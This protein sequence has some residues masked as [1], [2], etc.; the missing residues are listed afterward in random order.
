MLQ[1]MET[2]FNQLDELKLLNFNKGVSKAKV[3]LDP[4]NN[5]EV[6]FVLANHNPRSPKL[7]SILEQH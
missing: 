5:P 2:Q 1:T 3:K 4:E 6:I 7:R